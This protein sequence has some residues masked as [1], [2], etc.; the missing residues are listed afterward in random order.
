VDPR[1][2]MMPSDGKMACVMTPAGL[3]LAGQVEL[4]GLEAAPNWQRAEVLLK[5]A[6]KVFPGL[7]ADLPAERVKMWMGHRPSTPDGLPVLGPASG[8]GDVI[9]AFGH[10]H[11]GLTAAAMSGKV[12]ADLV[13]GRAPRFDLSPYAAGRFR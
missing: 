4:A 5:F 1:Y 11:V 13:A 12:V 2:P 3:R 10:G 9:H 6:R 8:C 7:P